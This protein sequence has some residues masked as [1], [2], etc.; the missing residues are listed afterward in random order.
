VPED[1]RWWRMKHELLTEQGGGRTYVLVFATGDEVM[2]G[3]KAFAQAEHLSAS[4]F[5]GIGA[6]QKAMLGYLDCDNKRYLQIPVAEQVE[7]LSIVGNIALGDEGPVIHAHVVLGTRDGQARGGHLVEGH[8]RPTLE[9]FLTELPGE[10]RKE[11][12]PQTGLN[13]MRLP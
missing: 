7:L 12:D 6:L 1:G 11:H 9:L 10:L 13:L 8:V 4:H 5:T 2:Q 3:L